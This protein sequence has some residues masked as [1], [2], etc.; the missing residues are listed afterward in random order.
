[1][2]QLSINLQ[3]IMDQLNMLRSEQEARIQLMEVSYSKRMQDIRD[4]RNKLN[5]TLDEL[6]NTTVKELD[7]IRTTLQTSIM[8][9]VDNCRR[10]KDELLKLDDAVQSLSEKSKKEIQFIASRKC[11]VKIQESE[12]YLKKN[13]VKDHSLIIFQADIDIEHY[14]SKKSGLGRIAVKNPNQVLTVKR[15]SEYIV[16][17]S[18][19]TNTCNIQGICVMPS[20]HFIVVDDENTNVKLLDLQYNIVS[21]CDL[22]GTLKDICLITSIEVAVII[23]FNVQFIS[24]K[25]GQLING[26]SFQLSHGSVG[27]A[28]HQGALYVTSG[29]ALYHYTL[30]GTLVKKMFEDTGGR[31]GD[32]GKCSINL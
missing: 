24:V 14:L 17:I 28:H 7:E 31:Y 9:D 19:D 13:S 20:G 4:M 16:N 11:L 8:N 3:T 1:M 30:T 23:G 22:S 32:R 12:T 21:H 2:K 15:R 26:R 10:L 25:N 6:E 27:I 5:A 18:S 29:T